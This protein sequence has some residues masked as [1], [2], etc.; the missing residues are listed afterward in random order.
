[1]PCILIVDGDPDTLESIEDLLVGEGYEVRIATSGAEAAEM[2]DGGHDP[3][4]V[5]L[6]ED[7]L[8]LMSGAEL[9]DWMRARPEL[10]GVPAILVSGDSR[11]LRHARAAAVL[12][13]PF[14]I[15]ELLEIARMYCSPRER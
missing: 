6:V 11:P 14:S 10:D 4:G 7:V 3:P 13:K 2:M 12:R 9:L 5:V 15:D 1:M 8:P